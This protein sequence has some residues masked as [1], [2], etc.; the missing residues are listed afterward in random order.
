MHKGLPNFHMPDEERVVAAADALRMLSDPT[1]LKLMWALL[2]GEE[3]VACL[4]DL[5]GARPTAV[6]QHLS[7]L[8]LAGLVH[9]RREGTFM[10]YTAAGD[11]LRTILEAALGETPAK[12]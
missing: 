2:E 11:H 3:N 10:Y 7:K 8:K 6:S 4:A 12:Q 1:R 9:A 5:V